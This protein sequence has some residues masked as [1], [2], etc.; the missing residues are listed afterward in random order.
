MIT[1]DARVVPAKAC[2]VE[3]WLRQNADSRE[4]WALPG[5]NFTGNLE[6]TI[7]GARQFPDEGEIA[8]SSLFQAKTLFRPLTANS[9]GVGLAIGSVSHPAISSESNQISDWYF[10]LPASI[11]LGNDT[12]IFH[13]N[14]GVQHEQELDRNKVTFGFG[15]EILL[16]QHLQM[17]AEVFGDQYAKPF[18]Q[19]GLR[20]W[21]VPE[22]IQIDTTYGDRFSNQ[23]LQNAPREEWFSIG[24]RLISNPIL[25]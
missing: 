5:C 8:S 14:L 22:S 7:G 11:S 19:I 1:D 23:S 21:L 3:S 13:L 17:I 24:L 10:Y 15:S 2:Q 18:Y 6:L 4:F 16:Y 20:Y 12:R 25:P 9:Y